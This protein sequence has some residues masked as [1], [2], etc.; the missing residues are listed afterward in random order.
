MFRT[1][2]EICIQ[3]GDRHLCY[4]A[5]MNTLADQVNKR[6]KY[7]PRETIINHTYY[8]IWG[9][10]NAICEEALGMT[11]RIMTN[12]GVRLLHHTQSVV[13]YFHRTLLRPRCQFVT[14]AGHS[15]YKRESDCI[16]TCILIICTRN[17]SIGRNTLLKKS[18]TK[19]AFVEYRKLIF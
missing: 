9:D 3:L 11:R 2:S 17:Y 8:N 13:Q 7:Q 6:R 4:N 15:I 14:V 5:D 10:Q 16:C 19:T 12:N 18:D 1:S